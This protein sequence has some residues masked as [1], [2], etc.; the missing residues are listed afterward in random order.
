MMLRR[1]AH[2][3]RI[4][5]ERT[6][7]ELAAPRMKMPRPRVTIAGMDLFALFLSAH[8]RIQPKPFSVAIAAVYA[9]ALLSQLLLS[10]PALLHVGWPPFAM[11]QTAASWA[12]FC[13]HAKRLH[14]GGRPVAPAAA[15]AILYGL[16]TILLLLVIVAWAG[17][18]QSDATIAPT[19]TF[20]DFLLPEFLNI[21]LGGTSDLGLF[22]RVA[23]ALLAL[24]LA[25]MAIA[26]GFS[27]W[28]WSRPSAVGAF[29]MR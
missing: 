26:I 27:I 29:A 5:I 20:T 16:S 23:A 2:C 11:V 3:A 28:T 10:Q 15:I 17:G 4:A 22:G 6:P 8:G 12:W 1:S 9:M 13:L 25:P 14:D 7:L 19:T 24:S 21:F 18:P